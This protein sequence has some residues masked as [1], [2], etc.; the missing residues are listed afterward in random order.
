MDNWCQVNRRGTLV[1]MLQKEYG[2]FSFVSSFDCQ[3]YEFFSD[4]QERPTFNVCF[5]VHEYNYVGSVI[6]CI[7]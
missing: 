6:V 2:F 4:L 5:S 1:I 3:G 7:E